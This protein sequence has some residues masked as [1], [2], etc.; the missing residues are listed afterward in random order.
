MTIH[1][2]PAVAFGQL[3]QVAHS[4]YLAGLRFDRDTPGTLR[5]AAADGD[6]DGFVDA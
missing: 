2:S 3:D 4:D 5:Q 1:P 6:Q